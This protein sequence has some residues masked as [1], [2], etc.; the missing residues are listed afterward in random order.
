MLGVIH[1][2]CC[3]KGER[4]L[5]RMQTKVDKVEGHSAYVAVHN[6]AL[7]TNFKNWHEKLFSV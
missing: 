1:K 6:E 2:G 5:G 3:T 7:T 4:R